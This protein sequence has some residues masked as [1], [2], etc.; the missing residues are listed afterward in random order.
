MMP[1]DPS[2][3]SNCWPCS[4]SRYRAIRKRDIHQR[5]YIISC[6]IY[7]PGG[8]ILCI[9]SNRKVFAIR[10]VPSIVE[11]TQLIHKHRTSC[12]QCPSRHI[13]DQRY[14]VTRLEV[15]PADNQ[16]QLSIVDSG[17][18]YLQ[19]YLRPVCAC[20]SWR[21]SRC[22]GCSCS[23]SNSQS[24]LRRWCCILRL[25]G[26]CIVLTRAHMPLR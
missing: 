25:Q 14:L 11:C 12:N 7:C 21:Q 5:I 24:R 4:W 22:R 1:S 19:E 6:I 20:R 3:S 16:V 26:R 17:R 13:D 9:N 2:I 23:R 18:A 10:D 8:Q 15:E